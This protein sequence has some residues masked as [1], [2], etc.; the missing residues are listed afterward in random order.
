MGCA[1]FAIGYCR[2]AFRPGNFAAIPNSLLDAQKLIVFRDAIGAARRAGLDLARVGGDR[3]IGDK[4]VFGLARTV[5]NDR[6]VAGFEC[7]LHGVQSFGQ[8][9]DLIDFDQNRIRHAHLDSFVQPLRVGDKQIVADEL[10]VCAERR[11]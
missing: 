11:R 1:V 7:R 8:R 10:R 4:G 3:E 9:A 5:R 6:R 2:N